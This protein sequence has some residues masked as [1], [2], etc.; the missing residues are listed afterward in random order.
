M[1]LPAEKMEVREPALVSSAV[2][3]RA[4][5]LAAAVAALGYFVDVFDMWL[6]SN[7][8]VASLQSLGLSP[9]EVTRVGARILNFQQAGLLTGGFLWGILADKQ[10]RVRVMFGSIL[11]YSVTTL[12]TAFIN[13]VSVY[14]WLRYFTGIGLAGEIGAGI[15][16][17]SE[18]L[19][20]DRRGYATTAVATLGVSGAL[21]AGLVSKLLLWRQAYIFGA[22][23]G[24]ALLALR[25]A[26]YESGMFAAI[27][28]D[29][30]IVRGSL[31]LLFSS[32]SRAMRF[33]SCI[34]IG[35]PIY[36]VFGHFM[37]FAPEV[38]AAF[39]IRNIAVP[40]VIM[41]G[42]LG[43]TCGDLL[44]GI[45]SQRLRSRKRPIF[46]LLSLSFLLSLA[47]VSGFVK[48]A[49]EYIVLNGVIGLCLGYWTCLITTTAEQFGTNLRGTVTTATP[50]L[51]RATII[52]INL[53]FVGFKGS[54]ITSHLIVM[55][56]IGCFALAFLGLAN[57][58]ETYGK[59]LNFCER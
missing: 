59:D 14:A 43:L 50:N 1:G 37:A 34:F 12:L 40:D 28:G 3:E 6:F 35:V 5:W 2:A 58:K 31:R 47:L 18:L 26:V 42:S 38:G 21:A 22:V 57:I 8:R 15:T 48:T 45:F 19:P 46:W 23:L 33:V 39:G 36:L 7:L 32:L 24:L 20:S 44:A 56:T 55:L 49:T 4:A 30:Q 27:S 25:V 52:P 10:G 17:V 11:L 13:D 9:E 16:L 29:A 53:I 51:I 54:V 41:A